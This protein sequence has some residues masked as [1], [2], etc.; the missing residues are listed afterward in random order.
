[1]LRHFDGRGEGAEEE[2]ASASLCLMMNPIST[3]GLGALGAAMITMDSS[4]VNPGGLFEVG[5]MQWLGA[6]VVALGFILLGHGIKDML[7]KEVRSSI[8]RLDMDDGSVSI[9]VDSR[10]STSS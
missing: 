2:P 3:I 9:T 5:V 4:I 7:L 10:R 1:M 8:I 6:A